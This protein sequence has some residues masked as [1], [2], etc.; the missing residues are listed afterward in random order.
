MGTAYAYGD[1]EDIFYDDV[2][3]VPE[4]LPVAPK[5]IYDAEIV[6]KRKTIDDLNAQIGRLRATISGERKEHEAFLSQCAKFKE[7]KN[8]Q[9]AVAGGITHLVIEKYGK[10][11]VMARDDVKYESS[12]RD[13]DI[14]LLTLWGQTK[15]D[16][17]WR[18]GQYSDHS[19]ASDVVHIATSLE[20]ANGIAKA[21]IAEL[22]TTGGHWIESIIK[23][24]D[25]FGVPVPQEVRRDVA[26][27][28]RKAACKRVEE[29]EQKLREAKAK[30]LEVVDE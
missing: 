27:R 3:C 7:L 18:L 13:R 10:V 6:E 5:P 11:S 8:L 2:Q 29:A 20:E 21:R 23:S 26:G 4:V 25:A 9:A 15:G 14:R 28:A 24:A 17:Q 30:L 1:E 19:G 22:L 12:S 16:L